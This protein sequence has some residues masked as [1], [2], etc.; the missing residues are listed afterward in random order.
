EDVRV[1]KK[2]EKL[3]IQ[4]K[5]Q[6]TKEINEENTHHLDE[7]GERKEDSPKDLPNAWR[8]VSSR[9]Q[10]LIIGDPFDGV[11]TRSYKPL[12]NNCTL[13]S[14]IEPK[15]MDDALKDE[16]WIFFYAKGT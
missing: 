1:R 13:L 10:G 9:P 11:K 14:H 12:Y 6:E 4:E 2:L 5:H 3:N 15:R 8:F 16:S 7:E